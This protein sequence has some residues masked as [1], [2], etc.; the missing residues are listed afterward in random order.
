MLLSA[1]V[2]VRWLGHWRLEQCMLQNT[3][4]NT[5]SFTDNERDGLL[6]SLATPTPFNIALAIC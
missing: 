3:M 1:R 2:L 4:R 5:R 6:V